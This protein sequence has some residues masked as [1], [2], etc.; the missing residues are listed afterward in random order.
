MHSFILNLVRQANDI[1]YNLEN[2]KSYAKGNKL[3]YIFM[4]FGYKSHV[5]S[6]RKFWLE[7]GASN[8]VVISLTWSKGAIGSKMGSSSELND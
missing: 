4:M 3:V 6:T 5:L 2:E 7:S 1:I 8:P